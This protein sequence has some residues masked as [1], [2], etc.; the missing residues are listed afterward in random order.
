MPALGKAREKARSI[1]CLS[2]LK[3]LGLFINLYTDD[4]NGYLPKA[5]FINHDFYDLL[6]AWDRTLADL[7]L[8]KEFYRMFDPNTSKVEVK[9]FICPTTRE[10]HMDF[11]ATDQD[12]ISN[13]EWPDCYIPNGLVIKAYQFPGDTACLKRQN[14]VKPSSNMLLLDKKVG[15]NKALTV[16]VSAGAP[17]V[18]PLWPF[19]DDKS[20]ATGRVGYYHSAGVNVLW[21]DGHASWEKGGSLLDSNL[22]ISGD[23]TDL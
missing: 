10:R 11:C 20:E 21:T 22:T 13:A 1:S 4:F 6:W 12:S 17:F 8:S 3:Q 5:A 9:P 18:L 15:V 2:N 7:Y 23:D 14:V 16:P 19:I